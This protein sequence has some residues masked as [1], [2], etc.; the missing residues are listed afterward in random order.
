MNPV[1][2]L[3]VGVGSCLGGMAR[4]LLS[5]AVQTRAG[6]LFPW[7]TFAV[8]LAGCLVLGFLYGMLDRGFQLSAPL[9]LF[10]TVGFCG[11]FTT[12]S[13]FVNENYVLFT[14]PAPAVAITYAAA[15]L[16]AGLFLLYAGYLAARF[17]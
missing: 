14:H 10:L 16:V 6:G 3:I 7:G 2:V 4:Y 17:F 11:G 15:T 8:N 1:D 9:K 13:T 5:V 12:F